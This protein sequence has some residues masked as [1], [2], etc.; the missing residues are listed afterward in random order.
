MQILSNPKLLAYQS[1]VTCK[2]NPDPYPKM[3]AAG[4]NVPFVW[5]KENADFNI[6][7]DVHVENL[8]E[9]PKRI[10]KYRKSTI[11]QPGTI[12]KHYG[13]ADDPKRYQDNYVYG[14]S[15]VYSEKAESLIKSQ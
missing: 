10:K 14:K 11:N 1:E 15:T 12:L 2:I 3:N 4:Y 6:R 7:P 8:S 9:T 5:D 13:L